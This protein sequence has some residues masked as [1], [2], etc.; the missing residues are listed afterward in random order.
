MSDRP[1]S[2][3]VLRADVYKGGVLAAHL[4]R[5]PDRVIF[6]YTADWLRNAGPAI[7]TT[8]PVVPAPVETVGGAVPAFFAGLLPEGRR[9]SA[10]R[11]AVKTSVDDDLSLLVEVG[12]DPVG[13]VQVVPEGTPPE[14]V[15]AHLQVASFADLRFADVR[16]SVDVAVDHTALAGV[17]DKVSLAMINVP[18][19]AEGASWILKLNPP[20][21]PR[22]V[23]NEAFF[24]GCSARSRI[25]TV[26]GE[27]RSDAEGQAGLVVERFDRK[28][29]R[30]GLR[31]FAVEDGCQV[32]G[33][34]PAA[35]YL[36][37]LEETLGA[38]AAVCAAPRPA[39]LELLRQATFAYL[40][41]NGD[42]HAKNF[43][44]LADTRG[45]YAPA[46]AYD[47]PSS[48]PYGDATLAL[49][50]DG[51]RDGNLTGARFRALGAALG[52]PERAARRAVAE[53]ADAADDWL[54]DVTSLP[55]DRDVTRKLQ[56][57]I[58]HRQRLLRTP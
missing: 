14:R 25:A 40:T 53:T 29:D 43:S 32:R 18:V 23:E 9:L 21:Y 58:A 26:S 6:A 49:S 47:L 27:L 19:T 44:V 15:G 1:A 11:R 20:E 52:L 30:D 2:K 37:S 33:R 51:A 5:T 54:D 46:P 22:L 16:A 48:Q 57:V 41:A 24:L 17:Q 34:Y 39:A 36:G 55:F 38:L 56:R 4:T 45:R 10:L 8:L 28:T 35:K 50:V 7:A 12:S 42:A 13:D 3:D 31:A